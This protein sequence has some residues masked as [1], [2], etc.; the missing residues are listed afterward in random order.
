M[1][2]DWLKK[3]KYDA[4]RIA[5]AGAGEK[6][7]ARQRP[8]ANADFVPDATRADALAAPKLWDMRALR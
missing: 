3:G 2:K 5:G 6:A 8:D 7:I 4:E 1:C